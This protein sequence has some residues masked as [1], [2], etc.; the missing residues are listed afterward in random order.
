MATIDDLRNSQ[1][2][3]YKIDLRFK[4]SDSIGF[5]L[6]VEDD[7]TPTV[8]QALT[9]VSGRCQVRDH[10]GSL[11]LTLDVDVSQEA[12]GHAD[13]GKVT[14]SLAKGSNITELDGLYDVEL[15]SGVDLGRVTISEGRFRVTAD[16]T[17]N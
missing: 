2:F 15:D 6:I 14:C 3:P 10:D 13:A 5:V 16:R 11:L 8:P 12:V 1:L 9:G 4:R 7:S 17:L